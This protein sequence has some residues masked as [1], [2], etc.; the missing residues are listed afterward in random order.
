MDYLKIYNDLITAAKH[1][2]TDPTQYFEHHHIIPKCLGGDDSDTNM[3]MLLGREHFIAHALLAKIYDGTANGYK[4][5]SAFNHMCSDG[6]NGRRYKNGKLYELART[7]FSKNHPCKQEHI[8]QK[9]RDSVNA[10]YA[11]PVIGPNI[12]CKI[13]SSPNK[14]TPRRIPRE[15]RICRCGCGG[16]FSVKNNSNQQ[17]L[18]GHAMH[19]VSVKNKMGASVSVAL[20]EYITSLSVDQLASRMKLSFG[21]CDHV[22]RGNAI[23]SGKKGKKTNQQQIMGNRYAAMSDQEFEKY[24]GGRTLATQTRM[25]NLR[26]R[27]IDDRNNNSEIQNQQ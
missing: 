25:K 11:D 20:N 8:R 12:I 16:E 13:L 27:Y 22:E 10:N 23:S 7:L 9:I 1:R 17:Y 18:H 24:I 2:I 6:H 14:A 4:L 21:S 26:K 19:D 15:T 3:V 5:A